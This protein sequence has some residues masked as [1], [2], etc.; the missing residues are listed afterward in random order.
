[1][2]KNNITRIARNKNN[3]GCTKFKEIFKNYFEDLA[4]MNNKIK[5]DKAVGMDLTLC[6]LKTL[7]S[8]YCKMA[9][10][11]LLFLLLVYFQKVVKEL[12]IVTVLNQKNQLMYQRVID[13]SV[14]YNSTARWIILK[15]EQLPQPCLAGEVV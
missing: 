15:L 7:W 10:C 5:S 2:T 11:S 4:T 8:Q 13:Q 1:M 3:N 12:K 14:P 6:L 9:Y